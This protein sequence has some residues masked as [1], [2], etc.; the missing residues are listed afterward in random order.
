MVK[1]KDNQEQNFLTFEEGKELVVCM[2]KA[3]R[4]IEILNNITSRK[5][6]LKWVIMNLKNWSKLKRIETKNFCFGLWFINHKIKLK[7]K[8]N[9]KNFYYNGNNMNRVKNEI[10]LCTIFENLHI[11]SKLE[12]ILKLHVTRLQRIF[13]EKNSVY[14]DLYFAQHNKQA[15]KNYINSDGVNNNVGVNNEEIYPEEGNN[16]KTVKGYEYYKYIYN[17]LNKK[18]F[19]KKLKKQNFDLSC[20][21]FNSSEIDTTY[22]LGTNNVI[23]L[24]TYYYNNLPSVKNR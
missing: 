24:K 21:S 10:N 1:L 3:G 15:K 22:N 18:P 19:L 7:L 8:K 5:K 13:F 4:G 6:L 14:S 11:L 9:L 2:L 16:Y 23:A 12:N 20:T 17:H